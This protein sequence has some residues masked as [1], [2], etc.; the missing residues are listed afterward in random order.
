MDLLDDIRAGEREQFVV[1]LEFRG[2]LGQAV[3]AKVCLLESIALNEG[4]HRAIEDED[5]LRQKRF[6]PM[7]SGRGCHNS[8]RGQVV[9]RD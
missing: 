5:A 9:T 3:A 6:D 4:A 7:R 2:V 1:P 8:P